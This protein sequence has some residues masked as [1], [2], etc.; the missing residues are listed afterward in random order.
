[1]STNIFK[2]ENVTISLPNIVYLNGMYVHKES[3]KLYMPNS[4]RLK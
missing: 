2:C 4:M 3:V 1:M